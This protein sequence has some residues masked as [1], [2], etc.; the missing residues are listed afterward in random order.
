[1][2]AAVP[3][4]HAVHYGNNNNNN[5]NNNS[6]NK[7]NNNNN[8]CYYYNWPIFNHYPCR[9]RKIKIWNLE[10]AVTGVTH[11]CGSPCRCGSPRHQGAT[12]EPL[13]STGRFGRAGSALHLRPNYSP[14]KPRP[15]VNAVATVT[16]G[17]TVGSKSSHPWGRVRHDAAPPWY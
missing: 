11:R 7:N 6:N 3:T 4:A 16:A 9:C 8:N 13:S 12:V 14:R 5:S 15:V 1:M 2:R 17:C 10:N